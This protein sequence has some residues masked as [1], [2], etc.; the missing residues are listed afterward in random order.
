MLTSP[1]LD[2]LGHEDSNVPT[3]WLVFYGFRLGV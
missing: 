2:L 3:F 1:T